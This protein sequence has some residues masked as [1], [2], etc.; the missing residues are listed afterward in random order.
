MY[1]KPRIFLISIWLD[2]ASFTLSNYIVFILFT[3]KLVP[4][5]Y[6]FGKAP[7]EDFFNL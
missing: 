3:L 6:A 5:F 1:T 7:E 2:R 4:K